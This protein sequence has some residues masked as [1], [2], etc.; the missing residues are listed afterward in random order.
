M[1]RILLY[2]L[3]VLAS[4]ITLSCE[5][6]KV[7]GTKP[8]PEE[9]EIPGQ[10]ADVVSPDPA[11]GISIDPATPDADKS[12]TITFK[13]TS[14]SP[15]Y[16]A[17]GDLYAHLGIILPGDERSDWSFV[18]FD[19]N[20]NNDKCKFASTGTNEWQL[21][22]KPSIR[23]FFDTDDTPIGG[24]MSIL[25]RSADGELKSGDDQFCTIIDNKYK[26]EEFTPDPVEEARMPEGVRHGINYNQDGSVTFVLYE[27]NKSNKHHKYCYIIGDWNDWK[28]NSAGAMKRDEDAGCWWITLDGFN[29][30]TEYRFQYRLGTTTRSD[31]R[32]SDPYTEIVYDQWN[33]RYIP[34]VR[35]FPAGAKALISAFQIDKPAYNWKVNDFKIKDKHNIVIYEMLIRD[36]TT[37]QNL[38]GVMSQLDYIKNLGVNAIELMPVMEFDGN[39]SWGYNPNHHFALDKYYGTREQYKAF[40][41]EC[42]GRG[43]AVILDVVYN[44]ATGSHPWAKL[45]WDSANNRTASNNPWFNAIAK[46]PYNVYHDFNHENEMVRNEIKQSLQY[47]LTEYKVDGFRFDLSKGFTQ[48]NSGENEAEFA[49]YDASRIAILKDYADA[50]W[51]VNKDAA[52]ILEHFAEQSEEKELAEYGTQLWRNCNGAYRNAISGTNADLSYMYSDEPFGGYVSYMES[53]DEERLCYGATSDNSSISWGICGTMTSWGT[54][55]DISMT[56]D[57]VFYVAKDVSFTASDQFKI[58][59]NKEWNDAYNYGA[60][61]DGYKLPLNKQY[62]MTSGAAS[63]NMA[64][65][66]AGKY[67]IYFCPAVK[68]VWLMETGKRPDKPQ[69]EDETDK[70]GKAM[71]RAGCDAA[72]CLLVPGPKMI[73]QFGEIGYDYSINYND[74][75]GEKPVVTSQYLAVPERK[76]LYDT[77]AGL[78]KFRNDNPEFFTKDADFKWYVT[79]AN[80]PGKYIYNTS[81]G[82]CFTVAGNFG[83]GSRT[84][85]VDPPVNGTFYNYFDRSETYSGDKFDITLDEGEWR[86]LV[87]F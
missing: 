53:H 49:R 2:S 5:P 55:D 58:R 25:V 16:N 83:K 47:L 85:A 68:S 72:F 30:A 76:A 64:V 60:S 36:F 34:G 77:Y 80:Y 8:T 28:R 54:K 6:E 9:P 43:L 84:L 19:W 45:Y 35:E 17:T 1:R 59:G 69:I 14:S 63:K 67:D 32:I 44:H 78:L 33:D 65:P 11:S 62:T 27:K 38:A 3:S 15:L 82:K 74:R 21:E 7:E 50:I 86:L 56:S 18:P 20:V 71:R 12:C 22:I 87:N 4:L 57:D 31:I 40:I 41:D 61:S 52:V 10:P 73:W 46:H 66:A 29:P 48:K 70:L 75:T 37:S 79:T 39:N 81:G 13:P 26:T 51:E 24:L 42:H 23:D